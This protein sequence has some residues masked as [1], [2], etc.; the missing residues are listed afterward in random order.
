MSNSLHHNYYEVQ[1]ITPEIR[2]ITV[3]PSARHRPSSPSF[4]L[5]A[6]SHLFVAAFFPVFLLMLPLFSNLG[7]SASL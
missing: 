1:I 5:P 4:G 6:L 7:L 2:L 3:T